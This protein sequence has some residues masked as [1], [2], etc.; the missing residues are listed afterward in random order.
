MCAEG[1]IC[2]LELTKSIF[3]V[4]EGCGIFSEILPNTMSNKIKGLCR[5]GCTSSFCFNSLSSLSWAIFVSLRAAASVVE[6]VE[7]VLG[8]SV[9]FSNSFASA[10]E[11][12]S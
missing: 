3:I 12:M 7:K 4:L 10:R 1:N 6:A 9:N 11:S 2:K 5:V 8:L